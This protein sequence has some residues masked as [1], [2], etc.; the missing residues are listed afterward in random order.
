MELFVVIVSVF[1]VWIAAANW[2]NMDRW[3]PDDEP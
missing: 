3:P 1:A 2:G